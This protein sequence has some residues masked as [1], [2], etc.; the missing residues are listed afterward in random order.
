MYTYVTKNFPGK[1]I[2]LGEWGVAEDTSA[3]DV[4]PRFF[5]QVPDQLK[6]FP[7]LKALVYFDSPNATFGDTRTNSTTRAQAAMSKLATAKA[8]TD[9]SVP[10]T[11]P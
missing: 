6:R 11:G 3:P 8:F 1:P 10:K 4:K 2:M 9:V 5:A 7:A